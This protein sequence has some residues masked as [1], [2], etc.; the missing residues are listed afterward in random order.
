MHSAVELPFTGSGRVES[1]CTTSLL[2]PARSSFTTFT[3]ESSS[4]QT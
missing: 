4:P 1:D 2:P 3:V